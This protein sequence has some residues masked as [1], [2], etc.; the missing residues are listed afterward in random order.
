MDRKQHSRLIHQAR[1]LVPYD[2]H[3]SS[4]VGFGARCLSGLCR[5]ICCGLGAGSCS[6]MLMIPADVGWCGLWCCHVTRAQ[7]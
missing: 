6:L 5:G 3:S 1:G 4:Y 7:C 2:G